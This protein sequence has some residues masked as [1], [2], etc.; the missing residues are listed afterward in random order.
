M[1]QPDLQGRNRSMA[2]K[3]QKQRKKREQNRRRAKQRRQRRLRRCSSV[4]ARLVDRDVMSIRREVRHIVDRA[5][6]RDARIVTLGD[7]VLFS[8]ETGDAWMLDPGDGLARCLA[9]DGDPLPHGIQE[10][11][12]EYAIEWSASFDIEGE[13]FVVTEGSGQIR[14]ILGYPTAEIAKRCRQVAEVELQPRALPSGRQESPAASGAGDDSARPGSGAAAGEGIDWALAVK[15]VPTSDVF[16]GLDLDDPGDLDEA[17]RSFTWMLEQGD[18]VTWEAAIRDEQDLPLSEAQEDK[19]GGLMRFV[20]DE[21][22][23]DLEEERILYVDGIGRPIEPWHASLRRLAR[24]L[25]LPEVRVAET[26]FDVQL[27]GWSQVRA[28]LV[29]YGADLPLP[30]GVARP[31]DVVPE[32]LRHRLEVQDCLTMLVGIGQTLGGEATV[33]LR[34]PEEHWRVD[35]LV[36]KLRASRGSVAALALTLEMLR[37]TLVLPAD[38][39]DV[40]AALVRERLGLDSDAE[41]LTARLQPPQGD[42]DRRAQDR[43]R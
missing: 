28:A 42:P 32:K 2:K 19:L 26:Y 6:E 17:V 39:W 27:E 34:D 24:H 36:E 37:E 43:G 23:E 3:T 10:T 22:D 40:F 7:L 13:R 16:G 30:A 12:E 35:V 15:D 18:F 14:T 20:D 4:E 33:S 29:R 11:N 5:T 25:L 41:P 31:L 9:Q 38:E 1:E 21:D 8:T